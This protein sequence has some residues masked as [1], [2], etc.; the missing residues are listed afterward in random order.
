VSEIMRDPIY[1][2]DANGDELATF[3]AQHS[4]ADIA[5]WIARNRVDAADV[6][7]ILQDILSQ[8]V[9]A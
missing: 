4:L 3:D 8:E 6:V 1:S 5:R 7:R 2:T 9:A